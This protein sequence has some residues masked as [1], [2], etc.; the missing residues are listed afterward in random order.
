MGTSREPAPATLYYRGRRDFQW[1]LVGA[2]LLVIG[3]VFYF[4]EVPFIG[5]L[6]P[7]V[8]AVFAAVFTLGALANWVFSD[9]Y[10]IRMEPGGLTTRFLLGRRFYKW[11]EIK[12]IKVVE[13]KYEGATTS[14]RVA[15]DVTPYSE[16]LYFWDKICKLIG[17]SHVFIND[18]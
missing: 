15:F 2:V 17:G 5:S 7:L 6:E 8:L 1:F 3:I 9:F 14:K 12:N 11:T 4:S 18:R 10:Y 13:T 16:G